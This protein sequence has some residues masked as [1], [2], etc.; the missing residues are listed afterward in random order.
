MISNYINNYFIQVSFHR[1]NAYYVLNCVHLGFS[2]ILDDPTDAELWV[3]A[4]LVA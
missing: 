2:D 4:R 3:D 1:D